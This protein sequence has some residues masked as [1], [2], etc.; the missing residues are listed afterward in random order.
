MKVRTWTS[1]TYNTVMSRE[2]VKQTL[3]PSHKLPVTF[4]FQGCGQKKKK[5]KER[6]RK[7]ERERKKER[8]KERRKERPNVIFKI[9][10]SLSVF[11]YVFRESNQKY[12]CHKVR[13]T[14]NNSYLL[15]TL[16]ACFSS[17]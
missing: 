9:L 16:P 11:S 5:K 10:L 2:R 15:S 12:L 6:K 8:K 1:T 3:L 13:K 17:D 7:K 14:E 4:T